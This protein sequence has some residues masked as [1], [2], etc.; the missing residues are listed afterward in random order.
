MAESSF[1]SEL[2]KRKVLQAAAIY[3][4][5]AFGVTEVVVTVVDRILPPQFAWVSTLAVIVFVVGFPVAMFLSWTFDITAEGIQRTEVSSRRGKASIALSILLMVAGTAGLFWLI[6]PSIDG[7]EFRPGIL[8]NSIAVLPFENTGRNKDDDWLSGGLSDELRDQLG[9]VAELRNSARSSCVAAVERGMDAVAASTSLGVAHI[10]E[11]SLRRQGNLLRVSVQLVD[12]ATGLAIWS[13]T[14]DR[15]PAELL[16]VQQTIAEEIV[17]RV[18]PETEDVVTAPAT[19][20]ATANE[21]MYRGRYY[22]QQVRDRQVRDDQTLQLAINQYRDAVDLDPESALAHS[23]LAGALLY[24]GDIDAAEAHIR[25]ALMLDA[26]LSE[27]QNTLGEFHWARGDPEAPTA[28]RRAVE[29]NPNDGDALQN[30]ATWV[31]S[32]FA[33][34]QLGDPALLF[35]RA[36]DNDRLSLE[37]HAALGEFLGM[38]GRTNEVPAVIRDIQALFDDAKSYRAVAWLY[39][40]L[41][42]VD[43]SIAWTM[44]ARTLEPDNPDHVERLAELYAIIGDEET[45]LSLDPSPS[46][47]ILFRMRRYD[48]LINEAE[49]LMIDRPGDM[50]LRYLLARAYHFTD[51][52][53]SAVYV[54]SS[55]G[56][57]ESLLNDQSR[58]V[59]EN[60]AFG[61]LTSALIASGLPEAV[62]AGQYLARWVTKVGL[63]G[64]IG[65]SA[66][67]ESCNLAALGRDQEALQ[68]LPRIKESRQLAPLPVLRD[69]WCFEKYVDDPVYQDVLHDQ[70]QRRERLR[71]RLPI[72]LRELGAELRTEPAG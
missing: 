37:R 7:A 57:P 32:S 16:S 69:S 65:W 18:L 63:H 8:P 20:N 38:H 66:L 31:A 24:L 54:L 64:D 55:T 33:G 40:L 39:Q 68:L 62:D 34:R 11:G 1:F 22:E 6:K 48:E 43:R 71:K 58:S 3:G 36:L 49:F 51:A 4:A 21:A 9:R 67:Y 25:T 27:V 56:L 12:G 45:S 35:R 44:R 26:Q 5:V 42:E 53:E 30:Y 15:G 17:R 70:E 23:R 59:F 29:L 28:W 72:T 2:R 14:F 13:E 46:L 52:H 19:N 61:T 47:G 50:E 41:G 10:V 60:E